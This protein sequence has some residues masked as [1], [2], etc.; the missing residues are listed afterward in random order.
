MVPELIIKYNIRKEGKE[1]NNS[2]IFR[3]KY[4]WIPEKSA[5]NAAM[6]AIYLEHRVNEAVGNRTRT[7]WGP[8]EYAA[9]LDQVEGI[10]AIIDQILESEYGGN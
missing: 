10:Y 1:L 5:D 9:A 6:L 7:S 8:E 2:R 3:G 4:A